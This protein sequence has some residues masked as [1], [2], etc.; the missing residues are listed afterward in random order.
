MTA[1]TD[2]AVGTSDFDQM[3]ELLTH[4]IAVH[5]WP[6]RCFDPEF[7]HSLRLSVRDN[8]RAM[9]ATVEGTLDLVEA[10]PQGAFAFAELSAELGIPVSELENAYWVGARGIWREWFARARSVDGRSADE[11][12]DHVGRGTMSIFDYVIH[13]L[14]AVV[15]RYDVTRAEILRNREDRRRE[16]L[17]QIL[18]GSITQPTTEAES[19]LGYR[20]RGTHVALT[21]K[22]DE[23]AQAERAAAALAEA[24]GADSSMLVLHAPGTWMLWLGFLAPLGDRQVTGLASAAA[25]AGVEMAVGDPAAG[26]DGLRR[27]SEQ[28]L[29]TARL[30]RRVPGGLPLVVRY[31]DVRIELLLLH[32]EQAARAFVTD[33][34]G[35]LANYD[36]RADRTCE[37][38]LAWLATGSQ[39]DA[40][41]QL[42]VHKNTMR[43]R[44]GHAEQVLGHRLS[45]RRPEISVALR[46][47]ELLRP[48]P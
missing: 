46:L 34:L 20:L 4:E 13:I 37:T 40:A 31:S 36:E 24:A 30:R 10:N 17:A 47:R 43:L 39:T 8:V 26:I 19:A 33:E 45:H 29:A 15:A 16:V 35:E 2:E 38:V 21:L 48:V 44:I 25:A 11:Q 12:L 6:D 23:R 5:V 22:V 28:A 42:G 1:V 32:D 18:D 41:A 9:L 14:G 3:V 27:T 7:V